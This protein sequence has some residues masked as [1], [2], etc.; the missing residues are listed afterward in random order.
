MALIQ[1]AV[2]EQ[3]TRANN[4]EANRDTLQEAL[5]HISERENKRLSQLFI[6]N[7]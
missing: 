6:L 1:C 2:F 5:A 3:L 4:K 7:A